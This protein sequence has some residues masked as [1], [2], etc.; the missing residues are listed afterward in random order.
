MARMGYSIKQAAASV[1]VPQHVIES[2]I[3]DG[4]LDAR[5]VDGKAVIPGTAITTWLDAQPSYIR[6][7]A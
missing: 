2:A 3:Q 6:T 7:G 4:Q 1:G 5:R